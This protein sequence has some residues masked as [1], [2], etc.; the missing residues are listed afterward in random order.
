MREAEENSLGNIYFALENKLF[1]FNWRN[2]AQH[3]RKKKRRQ[4]SASEKLK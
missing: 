2:Q 4:E 3:E 1:Y